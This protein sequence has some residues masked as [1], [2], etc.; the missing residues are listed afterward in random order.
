MNIVKLAAFSHNGQGGNPAGVAFY[1]AMPSDEEML[2]VARE[3][4]YSETAFLVRH[5]SDWRV[6]YFAPARE[7]R[8][9]RA[10]DHRPGRGAG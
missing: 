1:D 5:G 6:R 10:C 3:V 8:I 9:L 2:R 4:G 7:V